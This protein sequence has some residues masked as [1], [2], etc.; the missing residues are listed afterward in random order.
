MLEKW[1]ADPSTVGATLLLMGAVVA[2]YRGMVVP[3][4]AYDAALAFK[5]RECDYQKRLTE[6]LFEQLGRSVNMAE[7]TV[8]TAKTVAVAARKE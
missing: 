8:E 4:W 1:F 5:D 3:R 7:K 6:Q 2:F